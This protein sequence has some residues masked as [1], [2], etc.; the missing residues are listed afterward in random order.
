[1]REH[2]GELLAERALVLR[3]C[4]AEQLGASPVPLLG[5]REAGLG[6]E[7]LDGQYRRRVRSDGAGL[8]ADERHLP[9]REVVT[10]S[11]EPAAAGQSH[12]VEEAP[13]AD[14]DVG[15]QAGRSMKLRV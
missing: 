2:V 14:G 12:L 10:E 15:H 1:G 13:V 4:R 11:A 5:D 8:V 3:E 9:Y 6:E 7:N